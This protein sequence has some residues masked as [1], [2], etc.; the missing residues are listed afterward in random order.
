MTRTGIPITRL[1]SL[2]A[3]LRQ[4]GARA[5]LRG[6][7]PVCG[8]RAMF[9]NISP[10]VRES[11]KCPWCRAI[12]RNRHLALILCRELGVDPHHGL[13]HLA[14]VHP[15]LAIY[16]TQSRGPIHRFLSRLPQYECSEF[17][18]RT[19]RGTIAADGT[20]C[21]DLQCLTFP[22]AMFDVVVSQDVFEHIRDLPAA[23]REVH[24][25]LTPGG[26]HVFTVPYFRDRLTRRRIA[27]DGDR[28]IDLLPREYHRDSVR[29]GLVYTEFGG[30]LPALLAEYGFVTSEWC[31]GE[32]ER[33]RWGIYDSCILVSRK[34]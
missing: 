24:R 17:L 10:L 33:R 6:R 34:R 2:A 29:D 1:R 13:A 32:E 9:V 3:M 22:D 16:E 4:F 20:R 23:W 26:R 19:P 18:P 15:D 11:F 8:R 12:L 27:V 14:Q 30:D 28:E 31:A 7:C 21:E 25:V 5:P